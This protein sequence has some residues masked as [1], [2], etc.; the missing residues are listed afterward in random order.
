MDDGTDIVKVSTKK[1]QLAAMLMIAVV[2]CLANMPLL[3]TVWIHS[4]DDG[5]YS[6]AFLIPFISAYLVYLS[7]NEHR[8]QFRRSPSLAWLILTFIACGLLYL[9]AKAQI[10]L[11]YWMSWLMVM[12]TLPLVVFRFSLA[13]V[14]PLGYLIFLLPV[15]G[16]L[17]ALLQSLSVLVVSNMMQLTGIPVFV[18]GVYVQIPEGTFEI[19][20]GCSGLRYMIV[21]LAIASIY[22]FMFVRQTSGAVKLFLLAIAG[23]LVTNWVRIAALIVI[24]HVT[25]MQSSLME[26]HNMFGWYLYIPFMFLFYHVGNKIAAKADDASR[27]EMSPALTALSPSVVAAALLAGVISVVLGTSVTH[28]VMAEEPAGQTSEARIYP[29]FH[30]VSS[31]HTETLQSDGGDYTQT[32]FTFLGNWLDGKPSYYENQFLPPGWHIEEDK[33]DDAWRVYRLRNKRTL[34]TIEVRYRFEFADNH[35]TSVGAL[36]RARLTQVFSEPAI[37]R[38]VWQWRPCQR[39]CEDMTGQ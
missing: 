5:T 1:Q 10:S 7:V 19:A 20:D 18:E 21:S 3:Q 31:E 14:F 9:T 27:A 39:S 38:V 32:T 26:D 23:A 17:S 36:K 33:T 8:L 13:T 34:Q 24:G 37:S 16:T 15:W 12:C 30:H 22:N 29:V 2:I 4:F 6:H 35:Y 11:G 28:K 25:D